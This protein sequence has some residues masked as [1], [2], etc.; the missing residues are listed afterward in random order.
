MRR[1][2]QIKIGKKTA[3]FKSELKLLGADFLQEAVPGEAF[4]EA[5]ECFSKCGEIGFK[6]PPAYSR[7]P[8][9]GHSFS[10]VHELKKSSLFWVDTFCAQEEIHSY[11]E[12]NES[13]QLLNTTW[14]A[15]KV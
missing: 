10:C 2:K 3:L 1:D 5:W 14:M 13:V 4:T 8:K 7:V 6:W 15:D 12:F 9:W 11:Q